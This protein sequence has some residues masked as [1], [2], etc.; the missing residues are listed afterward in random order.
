MHLYYEAPVTEMF[1]ETWEVGQLYEYQILAQRRKELKLKQHEVAEMAGVQLRQYQ[2]LE[3]GERNITASSG[4]VML[5]VCEVLKLDPYLFMGTGNE[6]P[7]VKHIILP[8]IATQGMSY[9]IPSLSYYLLVSAIPRGM[10]CSSDELMACLR[11]AYGM[12]GLEIQTDHNSAAIYMNDC[13]PFWRVVSEDG[14]LVNHFFC[15]KEKQ[16]AYLEKEGVSIVQVGDQDRYHVKDY[17]FRR[18]DTATRLKI[19]VLKTDEQLLEQFNNLHKSE[20]K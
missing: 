16:H 12:E 18:F 15:S 4:K 3:S 9:V 14:N 2:R 1:G 10:V 7:E 13:F 11:K 19:T 6:P 8:P 17:H 5:A 20:D